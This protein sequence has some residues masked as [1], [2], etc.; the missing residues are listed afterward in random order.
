MSGQPAVGIPVTQAPFAQEMRNVDASKVPEMFRS[1]GWAPYPMAR[2]Y[3]DGLGPGNVN[4]SDMEGCYAFKG[5]CSFGGMLCLYNHPCSDDCVCLCPC[6]CGI[7]TALCFICLCNC[8]RDG[9]AWVN[10]DK[11]GIK[12]G[13]TLLVDKERGTMGCYSV[14]C[15]SSEFDDKPFCIGEK[16]C[17]SKQVDVQ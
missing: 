11:H 17:C 16:A 7:P 10:R 9:N 4:A 15:C 12:T 1:G 5:M 2:A 3:T 8:E 14:K 13:E 6:L